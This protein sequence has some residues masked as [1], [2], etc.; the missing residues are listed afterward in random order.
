M[1]HS[2]PDIEKRNFKAFLELARSMAP[3]YTPEWEPVR[4]QEPGVALLKIYLHMVEQIT[5]RLNETP[6][7]NF[8]AFL[9]MLGIDLKPAQSAVG[10]VTFTLAQGTPDNVLVPRGTEL[11]GTGKN[12][13]G[14]DEEVLFQ[15][16]D[17]LTVSTARLQ[18]IFSV[19]VNNDRIFS[20]TAAQDAGT[21]F[22]LFSGTD[23]QE[24]SLYIAHEDL[25]NQTVPA[26]IKVD[27]VVTAPA[28]EEALEF[29]WEYWDAELERWATLALPDQVK[30]DDKTYH[31]QMTGSMTLEK[32]HTAEIGAREVFGIENRWIRCRITE[33]LQ[34]VSPKRLPALDTIRLSVNPLKSFSPD[35][36]FNNDV[37]IEV[38]TIRLD[39]QGKAIDI[40]YGN[41]QDCPNAEEVR[42]VLS[43]P[44]LRADD[45]IEFDNL[46]DTPERRVV[47]IDAFQPDACVALKTVEVRGVDTDLDRN[48]YGATTKVT[49]ITAI[50]RGEVDPRV[51]VD[52]EILK[53]IDLTIGSK[54]LLGTAKEEVVYL[55]GY[56]TANFES[57]DL[58]G[59]NEATVV[60][61]NVY[62]QGDPL[63]LVPLIKPFGE[64]PLI[65]DT[66]YIASDEAFSKKEAK[67]TLEVEARWDGCPDNDGNACK[68]DEVDPVLSW[69][70][71][72][73]QSWRGIR[74]NDTTNRFFSTGRIT[75][76]CPKDIEKL[77]VNGEEKFWIRV[78]IIDG[79]YGTA[80]VLEPEDP[81]KPT[82]SKVV[83]K[84]GKIYFPIITDLK[85]NYFDVERVPQHCVTANNVD[86][87]DQSAKC[88][89][90]NDPF[91]P[92]IMYAE[93]RFP[94]FYLGFDGTLGLGALR[95]FFNLEEQT[96]S[97]DERLE[98]HWFYWNGSRWE[99]INVVDETKNLTE[100][101]VLEW[102]G[103][104]DFEERVLFGK[105]LYWMKAEVAVGEFP[106]PPEIKGLFLNTTRAIQS[107]R[108]EDE[109]LG[110]SD[111]TADQVF[112]LLNKPII[113][114]EVLVLEPKVPSED[115]RKRIE[116]EEGDDA[117][118]EVLNEQ[119]EVEQI[120]VRWHAVVDFDNSDTLSRHYR[121]DRRLGKIIF[122]DGV[123]GMVPPRG[124]DS[125]KATYRFGGGVIGNVG[126]EA[127][128][129][130]KNAIP[131][132][133]GVTNYLAADGGAE[134][135]TLDDV[136][137]RGPQRLKNRDRAVAREDYEW[138]ALE[139]RKV[140]RAKALSNLDEAGD[141][142]P[143]WV[144]VLIVPDSEEV[145]PRPTN[146]LIDVVK[147]HLQKV[148]A[149]TV[150]SPDHIHV[151]E[152]DYVE[153]VVT[154]TVIPVDV[155]AAARAEANVREALDR[156]IH[157]LT[158][159]AAGTGWGFGEA[160]C[161]SDIIALIERVPQVNFVERLFIVADGRR[162]PGDV[163]LE[164]TELP[165]SGDHAINLKLPL[166]RGTAR[167]TQQASQCAEVI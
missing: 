84:K 154:T 105:T 60:I 110:S 67:I 115:V 93:S 160:L 98:V 55:K 57:V 116:Q 30:N 43:P 122:S 52:A 31:F 90:E 16:T 142:T 108:I 138:Q 77:E 87:E 62:L 156:F 68:G 149:N 92:F 165:F 32:R 18:E 102:V 3:F 34:S 7:K 113:D 166:A 125:I 111:G 123:A 94:G 21:S 107:A 135:E 78:R 42:L 26:C 132:V 56:D 29:R 58:V 76:T 124:D 53:G 39:M 114:Q 133:D 147:E 121:V 103:S 126:A 82:E 140:A 118:Q 164:A 89:K 99:R 65:F 112:D 157:P 153:V 19:A 40:T 33:P 70:Y 45:L 163:T 146:Q 137:D 12:A 161:R 106:E 49:M 131:F 17:D 47:K 100:I 143:G 2:P 85:I 69:E 117:V 155:N 66:F 91:Q 63:Y 144:T 23:R 9:D 97:A 120:W 101:G 36:A 134:T 151:R 54:I 64:A 25:L 130:L 28:D 150:S 139:K 73:G 75:F 127:I 81:Q 167:K 145:P 15:T 136:L 159:G 10:Y 11:A 4:G 46:I 128:T 152:P 158:G 95:L 80:I 88:K 119:G 8:V 37:P 51:R 13:D 20:H 24:H 74:V 61:T 22:P 79:D 104:R 86:F 41:P 109:S 44:R 14:E 27:F 1:K 59:K 6:Y 129:A 71:W 50:R 141:R 83:V 72:N 38:D 162:Y 35:L 96:L 148:M 5:E 48:A